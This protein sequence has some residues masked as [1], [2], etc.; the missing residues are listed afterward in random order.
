MQATTR[1]IFD[2]ADWNNRRFRAEQV[3]RSERAR[4]EASIAERVIA[5]QMM[6]LEAQRDRAR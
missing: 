5:K 4:L 2:T 6:R 3:E 1:R